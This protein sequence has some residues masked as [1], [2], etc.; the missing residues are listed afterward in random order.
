MAA[1]VVALGRV[2]DDE[3]F[4]R[5]LEAVG[6]TLEAHHGKLLA[7]EDP[8]DVLEG[9]APYPRVVVIEFPS[10]ADAHAWHVS[11]EYRTCADDRLASSAHVLYLA[12]GFTPPARLEERVRG[13]SSETL[14]RRSA[15]ACSIQE[16][17]GHLGD[18]EPL[19]ATRLD[20]LLGWCRRAEPSRPGESE[21]SRG[22]PQ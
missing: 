3:R 19:W 11:R 22:R 20:E 17:V 10:K 18:L 12:D 15:D 2:D 1:Y 7:V 5:Y 4:A 8:A 6:P 16:H 14:I 9:E 13:W 21:D